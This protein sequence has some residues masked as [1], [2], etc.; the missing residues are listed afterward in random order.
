MSDPT[1]PPLVEPLL[2]PT[3]DVPRGVVTDQRAPK[4]PKEPK[5]DKD[6]KPPKVKP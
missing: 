3:V 1:P 6:P 4:P 2:E 5:P